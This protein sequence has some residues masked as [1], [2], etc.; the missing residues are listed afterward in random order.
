MLELKK[1]EENVYTEKK[2][3]LLL[4]CGDIFVDDPLPALSRYVTK[5]Q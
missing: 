2:L 4:T 5:T 3:T 1:G